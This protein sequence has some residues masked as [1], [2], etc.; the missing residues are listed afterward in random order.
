[1]KSVTSI[2]LQFQ[3]V[4]NGE[5]GSTIMVEMTR[6]NQTDANE[7][8]PLVPSCQGLCDQSKPEVLDFGLDDAE[9]SR[10]VYYRLQ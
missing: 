1:M 8:Q 3:I 6:F 10:Y 2:S 5:A 9:S 4:S 7:N